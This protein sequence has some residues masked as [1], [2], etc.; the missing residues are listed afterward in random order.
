MSKP[1]LIG[2]SAPLDIVFQA[3]M[4]LSSDVEPWTRL[5]HIMQ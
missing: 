3:P 2:A 4:P 5:E 1:V